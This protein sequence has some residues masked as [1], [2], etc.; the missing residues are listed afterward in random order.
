MAQTGRRLLL[1][2]LGPMAIGVGLISLFPILY[3]VYISFTNQN[4]YHFRNYSIV[5]FVN[6][7]KLFSGLNA[8]FFIVLGRTFLFVAIC[9]PLFLIVGMLA[10]MALNH[11][12]VKFKAFWRVALIIPWAV[13]SY[14]T[15]LVWKFFYNGDF[16]TFNQVYRLFAGPQAGLPWLTDPTWAFGSIVLTNIWMSY[17]FFMVVIL[18][19]LQSIPSELYEAAAV[20][21]AS[22][23]SKFWRITLPLLRPA[24]LPAT[25]L[26]AI[27][28]FN[29]LNTAYLITQGGPFISANKPGATEF[30]LVYA[31]RNA[32]QL[33]N[34]SYIA[35]FAV[36]IFFLLF[37]VTL[38]SLRFTGLVREEGR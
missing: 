16:G 35:A 10:A 7:G 21:G 28:T 31:F 25:I 30:V 17:P 1:T 36:V 19:A 26:S 32:F 5:G 33:F 15:A 2:Y 24:I 18:G 37:A 9:I 29:V 27:L 13:P 11:P 3:N 20:D 22:G 14:V 6:Y 23:W 4:L 34:Y 38:G 8:D 12:S